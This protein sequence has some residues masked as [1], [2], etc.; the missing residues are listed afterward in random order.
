[1]EKE[2]EPLQNDRL[3]EVIKNLHENYNEDTEEKFLA[4]LKNASF[5]APADIKVEED[6]KEKIESDGTIT[7]D[8]NTPMNFMLISSEDG[9]NFFPAFTDEEELSKDP[10]KKDA[11]IINLETYLEMLDSN[12]EENIA[13]IAINPFGEAIVIPKEMLIDIYTN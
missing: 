6:L 12:T 3:K 10:E 1:M 13:S 7:L 11:I 2:M 5:L 8:K 9:K 4:E